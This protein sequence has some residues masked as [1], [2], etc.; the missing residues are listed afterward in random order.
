MQ[1]H[2]VDPE[3]LVLPVGQARQVVEPATAEYVLAGQ[4]VCCDAKHSQHVSRPIGQVGSAGTVVSYSAGRLSHLCKL[5]WRRSRCRSSQR[6][7]NTWTNWRCWHCCSGRRC[8]SSL[9]RRYTIRRGTL[10]PTDTHTALPTPATRNRHE[11]QRPAEVAW[12]G[13]L[14]RTNARRPGSTKV[15]GRACCL[16]GS[17]GRSRHRGRL[18]THT[19]TGNDQHPRPRPTFTRRASSY[20]CTQANRQSRPTRSRDC[21][22]T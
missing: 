13:R 8:R 19:H 4:T 3:A 20:Q 1:A 14:P 18:N 10:E 11:N 21:T 17:Q 15:S 22:G 2:V 16:R 6:C 7:K 5:A 9:G 12:A